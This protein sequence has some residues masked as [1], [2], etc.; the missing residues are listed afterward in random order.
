[1]KQ[2]FSHEQVLKD[3]KYRKRSESSP[4][5]P[6]SKSA[7]RLVTDDID[8]QL[9]RDSHHPSCQ[10]CHVVHKDH[11]DQDADGTVQFK[12]AQKEL[13]SSHVFDPFL[14]P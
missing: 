1:M 10:L 3:G 5:R 2:V 7:N 8:I 12:Y 4:H 13:Y 9:Y 14:R 6:S 11:E